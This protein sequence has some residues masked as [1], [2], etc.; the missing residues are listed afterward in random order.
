M[1]KVGIIGAG[2]IGRVHITSI[3]TRVPNAVIK[4]VADPFLTEETAD[5]AKSM[6]VEKTTKDY[7]E[8]IED[9]EIDA[10][11]I[12][13]STDTHSPISIEAIKAGKHVF[14]EKPI[15]H[16]VDKIM[17]VI[18]ALE[19]TGLKYQVGFNRRFDHNFQSLQETVA[20]GKIGTPQIIKI[21][22][23]DPEPPSIDYVKVSGGMFLDMTIHDFDMARFLAG[24]DAEEV[25]VQSANL[26]DPAIGE[27][28]DVDTAVI[29]LKMENGA[30]AVI[31]NCR[32]AVYGYDQRA[33]V[34]GSEGMAAISND[35]QSTTVISNAQGVT[36]EK[37]MFFFLERYMDAYGK[38]ITAFIDAIEKGKDTPL[39]VYD[40]LKPV[41]MGLAAKKSS[42]EHRPV[43]ISEIMGE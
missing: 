43:K 30:I 11:L 17:E 9:P 36:G 20:Q 18:K 22:S 29:T 37:P 35:S 13:S 7:K 24:C 15:D 38:E 14:C 33:E 3:T 6:G 1:V 26:V 21:T 31:D 28:G 32:K 10:V 5:W 2:R 42:Q 4:T 40:G 41:L 27:A 39:N 34:F 12:C 25:Y 23:R 8:I 19:G 16:D